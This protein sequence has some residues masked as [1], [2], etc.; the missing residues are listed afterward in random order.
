MKK[1]INPRL[2]LI[3][4]VSVICGI[5]S[6][7]EILF[8]NF[9]IAVVFG[10]VAVLVIVLSL[11]LKRSFWKFAVVALV[12]FVLASA[13]FGGS[14]VLR[15]ETEDF[16]QQGQLVGRV[17]DIGRN[18]NVSNTVYLEK[19]MLDGEKVQGRVK[20]YSYDGSQ[21]HTGDVVE[22]CGTLRTAYA[23]NDEINS[24]HIRYGVRYELSDIE[25]V[26]ITEGGL[27]LGEIVRKYVYDV[28]AEYM[29]MNGDVA[30]ALLTGDRNAM[31]SEKV[32]A[33]S[34]AGIIHLLV[35]SGLHVGFVI[36]V[37]GFVLKLFKLPSLAELAILLVPLLFYAYVCGFAPSVM[38]A[39]IMSCCLYL[40]RALF[41]KYDL[42]SSLCWA[43][44]LILLAQPFHLYDSGF[45]MSVMSVFGIA[46]MYFQM[47][48]WYLRK[49]K[50]RALNWLCGT[51]S[52]SFACTFATA[53][54][55]AYYGNSVAY[56][57]ILVNVVAIPLVFVSFVISFV[58]LLPSVFHHVLWLA[59]NILEV[60]V[61]LAKFVASL[62]AVLNF[63]TLVVGIVACIVFLFIIGGYVNFKRKG[64]IL[65]CAVCLV[66]I[67]VCIVLS[68][69]PAQCTN[70]VKVFFGYKDVVVVATSEAGESAIVTSFNDEYSLFYA[71]QWLGKHDT[72]TTVCIPNVAETD[73]LLFESF[74]DYYAVE[75]VYLLNYSGNDEVFA[76]LEDRNIPCVR[77]MPNETY[78]NNIKVQAVYDGGLSAVVVKTGDITVA[79]VL[80][81]DEK[82]TAFAKSRTDIDYYAISGSAEAFD[83]R[84]LPTLSF[85]QQ[86]FATNFGAN[87]YGNF[88]IKQKDGRIVLNF[89]RN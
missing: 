84:N 80:C 59:D 81:E 23:V 6:C 71:E 56:L 69:F 63:A 34:A 72:V 78:G 60:V 48:R 75:K 39:V 15:G 67:A 53:F 5:V 28:T 87:K 79:N 24:Y 76:L 40:T 61:R 50:N 26:S 20:M 47:D 52:M 33:F 4:A 36:T 2:S 14:C 9:V 3:C 32:W 77:A 11:V 27:N 13:S 12:A 8:G 43:V 58:G 55:I 25:V 51:L 21:F 45:Q 73:M 85:Y 16:Q 66:A 17:S 1:L 70:C 31:D 10:V 22:I 42:L 54:L 64:R 89:R 7:H 18:G 65:S 68:Y 44:T 30:Y 41:G 57:G 49:I 37:F 19:C 29:P 86:Q 82:A 74:C 35:V 88:T 62:D 83:A 46:T 38:R